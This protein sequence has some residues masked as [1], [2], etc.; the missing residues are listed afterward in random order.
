MISSRGLVLFSTM[1]LV[2]CISKEEPMSSS[3]LP[4]SAPAPLD[5]DGGPL[6]PE[7]AIARAAHQALLTYFL[8]VKSGRVAASVSR[9]VVDALPPPAQPQL[10]ANGY[11]RLG[12]WILE[13]RSGKLALTYRP[14][15]P[16]PRLE[17][18]ATLHGDPKRMEV[19]SLTMRQLY[20]RR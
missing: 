4:N 18:V 6:R 20:A 3:R 14:V 12:A 17:Y 2:S 19:V 9:D 10:D 11:W 8:D 15:Q 16:E 5:L 7:E 1:L 13:S